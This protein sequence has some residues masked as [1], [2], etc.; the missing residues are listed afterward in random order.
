[1]L[2]FIYLF[3]T[4]FTISAFSQEKENLIEN[5]SYYKDKTYSETIQSVHSKNFLPVNNAILG[6]NNATFWFKVSVKSL[7][8]SQPLIFDTKENSIES[9]AVYQNNTLISFEK[10]SIGIKYPILKIKNY[11]N[12]PFYVKVNFKRQIHFPLKVYTESYFTILNKLSFLKSGFY[13]G[14]ITM[15]FIINLFFFLSLKDNTFFL[16]C[17]F[18]VAINLSILNYDGLS[19][20]FISKSIANYA[21]VLFHLFLAISGAIFATAFLNLKRLY[22]KSIVIGASLLTLTGV[23]YVLY[24]SFQNYIFYALGNIFCLLVLLVYWLMG[25]YVLKNQPSAKFF[26]LGYS[27]VLFTALLFAIP[28]DFGV[29]YFSLSI[30]T[31][32]LGAM[33]EALILTYAITHRVRIL[34][35]E[36]TKFTQDIKN[37]IQQIFELEEQ[38]K[39]KENLQVSEEKSVEDKIVTIAKEYALTERET[40]ILLQIINGLKNQQI[41]D[42]LFV[43]VNTIKYHTRNIYEKLDVKKRGDITTK[44]L[45]HS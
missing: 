37:H 20:F 4:F 44:I 18:L 25:V 14:F 21:T 34:H 23:L 27:L 41:A 10:E 15:V 5:I 16:Y 40:D 6:L 35:Q 24:I 13:Y 11:N 33:F 29:T 30:E 39:E 1:M 32:K 2:R 9:I 31:V 7:E 26:V 45:F 22:P 17:I 43:S 36:N 12:L 38:L 28:Q 42:K 19:F 8:N 3:I